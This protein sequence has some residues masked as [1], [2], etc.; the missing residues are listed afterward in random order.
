MALA[1]HAA[2]GAQD[3]AAGDPRANGPRVTR[4][5]RFGSWGYSCAVASDETG[6][7]IERCMIS[8]V[9]AVDPQ[10]RKVVLGLT[11]GLDGG[12]PVLRARFAAHARR[13][14]GVGIKVDDL[15]GFR[16]PIDNCDARRCEAVGRMAPPVL[17]AWLAGKR[18]QFAFVQEAGKDGKQVVLPLSLAGFPA[19]LAAL[20][21]HPG[22]A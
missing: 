21:A 13:A 18:A 3:P 1:V 16:L 7:A 9:V 11:V 12:V 15:P 20:R 22:K 5:Q 14:P 17:K 4:A 10:Q 19:A 8:Q 6:R 2:A